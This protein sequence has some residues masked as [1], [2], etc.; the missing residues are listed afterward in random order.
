[1]FFNLKVTYLNDY[2]KI[3]SVKLKGVSDKSKVFSYSNNLEKN[4]SNLVRAKNTITDLALANDFQYFFTLTFNTKFDRFNLD[5]L[6][7]QWK[8]QLRLIRDNYN[9]DLKY[10]IVPEQHKNGAWHFH[11]FM[12][13]EIENCFKFNEYGYIYIKELE[14]LGFHNFQKIEKKERIASYV[15]KY[16]SKN[17]AKG[18]NGWKHS[19]FASVG[20]SRG[21]K[22]LDTVYNN[23]H[24]NNHFFDYQNDF[25]YRKIL[26]RKQFEKIEPFLLTL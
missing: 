19:Y 16:V 8:K 7:H 23:E 22:G 12:T 5:Y 14:Y 3:T 6:R 18:I 26:T 1:M 9:I 4:K 24:F 13:K 11:G 17:L 21:V 10:L 20:L 25:C 2:V 15:T